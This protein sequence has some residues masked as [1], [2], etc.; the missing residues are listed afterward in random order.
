MRKPV[1]GPLGF[2]SDCQV[3]ARAISG[4]V[5]PCQPTLRDHAPTGARWIH[6]IKFDGYRAQA[7]LRNGQSAIYTRA[8]HN[9]TARFRPIAD[10]LRQLK[11]KEFVLDG[12]LCW[13]M[14][15]ASLTSACFTLP[16][17]PA[18][19]SSFSIMSS[20]CF[21][22]MNRP[23]RRAACRTQAPL[24]GIAGRSRRTDPLCRALGGQRSRN[25]RCALAPWALKGS[26]ASDAM[27]PTALGAWR[28]GSR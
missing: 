4:F 8:G 10:A 20:I 12:K 5:E 13:S 2:K 17:Q 6:E 14:R 3:E 25:L 24:I 22:S 28:A 9:W 21:I 16:W 27:P 23:P 15:A 1:A 7:H 11:A 19:P 18:A 26:S